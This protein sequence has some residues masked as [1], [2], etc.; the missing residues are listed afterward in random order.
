MKEPSWMS[1]KFSAAQCEFQPLCT[2]A[3]HDIVFA[4]LGASNNAFEV[5][6]VLNAT[7]H[8]WRMTH[9]CDNL[10]NKNLDFQ[11]LL[12]HNFPL[13]DVKWHF[14]GCQKSFVESFNSE[15]FLNVSLDAKLFHYCSVQEFWLDHT[16]TKE[17]KWRHKFVQLLKE[18]IYPADGGSSFALIVSTRGVMDWKSLLIHQQLWLLQPR[19][20]FF[21]CLPQRLTQLE[22]QTSCTTPWQRLTNISAQ[23]LVSA[24][25]STDICVQAV[26]LAFSGMN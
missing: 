12:A 2:A 17:N 10:K 25:H 24:G 23:T 8:T 26:C 7:R 3:K 21:F 1:L 19:F 15:H 6:P 20:F 11:W 22:Q 13:L 18:A 14:Q 4:R 16:K 5:N 9:F